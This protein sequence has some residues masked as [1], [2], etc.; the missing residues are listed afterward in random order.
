M[1]LWQVTAVG[2]KLFP[3]VRHSIKTNDINT[4]VCKIQHVKDHLIENDRVS[5]VQIP[6]VWIES[7]HDMFVDIIQPCEVSRCSSREYLWAGLLVQ[8]RNI[9]AVKEEVAVLIFSFTGACTF[10]P[11]MILR[12]VVHNKV[13]ADTDS[14]FVAFGSQM[15][16]IIHVSE[17]FLYLTEVSNC[18]SAIAASFRGLKK[19]HKM[20]IIYIAFLYIV[21]FLFQTGEST[22]KSI[23]IHHHSG[24]VVALVPFRVLCTADIGFFEVIASHIIKFL[25]YS[26]QVIEMHGNIRIVLIQFTVEPFQLVKMSG[27]T[28]AVDRIV[29]S[30]RNLGSRF[31]GRNFRSLSL[32][33]FY[34]GSVL[35]VGLDFDGFCFGSFHFQRFCLGGLNFDWF[36]FLGFHL[37]RLSLGSFYFDCINLLGFDLNRLS[38]SSLDFDWLDFF[39]FD[40]NRFNLCSFYFC[41]LNFLSFDFRCFS[42][43]FNSLYFY[44]F[45]HRCCTFGSSSL[46]CFTFFLKAFFCHDLFPPCLFFLIL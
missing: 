45:F 23:D 1:N 33:S 34:F 14:T 8:R 20:E 37:N 13:Q 9:V 27:K 24:K 26:K 3:D 38:L 40:L 15:C 36:N 5:V 28:L 19:R 46:G 12:S 42:L 17:L 30:C 35:F 2:S 4:L 32:G 22:G 16:K 21:Q 29:I 18:I 25:E 39:C 44:S 41:W 10:C 31:F 11:F 43:S 6:L 7:G